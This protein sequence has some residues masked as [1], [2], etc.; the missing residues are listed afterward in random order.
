MGLELNTALFLKQAHEDGC[1]FERTATLGHQ[2]FFL[3]WDAMQTHFPALNPNAG[4]RYA[5][6]FLEAAF[7]CKEVTSFDASDFEGASVVHDMNLPLPTAWHARFDAVIEMGSLE[8]IFNF[9]VAIHS[10]MQMTKVGGSL[11][12][13]TPSNNYLGHGFY[14]FGPDLFHRLLS[15]ANGFK[16]E[17][18]YGFEH[19]YF[20]PEMGQSGPWYEVLDPAQVR[21]R[22]I[23]ISDNPMLLMIRA[24]RV[25]AKIGPLVIPQQSDYSAMWQNAASGP[26]PA[27]TSPSTPA[28]GGWKVAARR[29]LQTKFEGLYGKI[30]HE[31]FRR[32]REKQRQSEHTLAG[33]PCFKRTELRGDSPAM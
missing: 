29:I 12:I 21:A 24:R 30:M 18:F 9:P 11:F 28:T 2:T 5:D 32:H 26:T 25:E 15:A 6:P 31:R 10:L 20:G 27:A 8:H 4:W 3:R 7:G 17:R 19:R 1:S 23:V 13:V 14:Q 33:S 16:I 22:P